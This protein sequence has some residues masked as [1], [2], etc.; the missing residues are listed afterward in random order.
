MPCKPVWRDV[1]RERRMKA[2]RGIDNGARMRRA[3]G[4]VSIL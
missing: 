1:P 3:S 4:G 2:W